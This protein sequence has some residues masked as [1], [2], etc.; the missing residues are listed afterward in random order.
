MTLLSELDK[1]TAMQPLDIT[2]RKLQ[3]SRDDVLIAISRI[4]VEPSRDN[5]R[6]LVAAWTRA[7]LLLDECKPKAAS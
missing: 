3:T 4:V 1:A 7:V 6:D 2:K 5:M